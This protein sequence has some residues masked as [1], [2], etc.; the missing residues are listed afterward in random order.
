M[1]T[2]F[3]FG[4]FFGRTL[5]LEYDLGQKV[6]KTDDKDGY[7]IIGMGIERYGQKLYFDG[8]NGCGLAGAGLNFTG[9]ARY[10]RPM[11][12]KINL[13]SYRF[14]P[15]VLQKCKNVAE[16]EKLINS[17]NITDEDI[18]P[19]L[20][21]TG[22]HFAFADASGSIVAEQTEQGMAVYKNPVD[23]LTN[24]PYFQSQMLNLASYMQISPCPPKNNICSNV[25]ITPYCRG[26]GAMGLPGD[27]SSQSRF[28]RGVFTLKNAEKGK[29]DAENLQQFFHIADAVSQVKGCNKLE[30]GDEVYT[31]YTSCYHLESLA[32]HYTT[33]QDR[34]VKT[35]S[36]T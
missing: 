2:A 25:Q 13:P 6:L 28:V 21:A 29:S 19:E 3:R 8:V 1:C 24:A 16:A 4:K 20:K 11:D 17:I 33:Y 15:F 30:N 14:L 18:S 31:V 36:N 23:L 35:V 5:D 26:M 22:L 27:Y 7:E 34:T 9:F 32:C 12:R 10:F